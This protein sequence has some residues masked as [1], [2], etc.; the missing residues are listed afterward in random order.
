MAT[1]T[2]QI[3]VLGGVIQDIEF[4]QDLKDVNV[5]VIDYDVD[6]EDDCQQDDDGDDCSISI[7]SNEI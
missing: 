7:W 4:P 2:I 3:T 1:K 5:K 6:N